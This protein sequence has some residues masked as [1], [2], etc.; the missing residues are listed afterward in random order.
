[1]KLC[2]VCSYP[3]AENG[4][5]TCSDRCLNELENR[6]LIAAEKR[7]LERE[8]L[9]KNPR[10]TMAEIIETVVG[11]MATVLLERNIPYFISN[12]DLDVEMC[13][14]SDKYGK[15]SRAYR[16]RC[17]SKNIG[18]IGYITH[19]TST[20]GRKTFRLVGDRDVIRTKLE[21]LSVSG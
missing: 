15:M 4:R 10:S 7:K 5:L 9:A 8:L 2:I 6:R 21:S 18:D 13:I 12:T 16:K 17:I 3:F 20:H 14:R 11:G 1:M 19:A